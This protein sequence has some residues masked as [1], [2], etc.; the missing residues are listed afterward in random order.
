[1]ANQAH[2]VV[3]RITDFIAALPSTWVWVAAAAT[4]DVALD[5]IRCR[6][7]I[8]TRSAG[9][10]AQTRVGAVELSATACCVTGRMWRLHAGSVRRDAG[11]G[12]TR[13]AVARLVATLTEISVGAG[14]DRMR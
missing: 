2:V 3:D 5:A 11:G 9:F 1:M 7:L 6:T 14:F 4:G 13:H 10:D 8:V 12:V